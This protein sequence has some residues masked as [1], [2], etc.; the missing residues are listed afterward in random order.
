MVNVNE[1][2]YGKR[3]RMKQI[4]AK[5]TNETDYGLREMNKMDYG[6]KQMRWDKNSEVVNVYN[7]SGREV[8]RC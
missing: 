1:M 4:E 2:N 6:L 3:K 8:E 7:K 5:E